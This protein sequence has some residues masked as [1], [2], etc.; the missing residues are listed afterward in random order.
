LLRG[1]ARVTLLD[2]W[3]PGNSRA[4]S[5]GET[6]VIRAI[7]GP[8][9]QYVC[10]AVRALELWKENEKRFNRKMFY[11]TGLLWMAPGADAY[12]KAALP[13]LREAGVDFEELTPA[14]AQKR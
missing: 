12:E 14:Q 10:M 7:Y 2:A 5:A 9:R 13:L 11:R 6:R 8:N 3:G 1:R 4:S